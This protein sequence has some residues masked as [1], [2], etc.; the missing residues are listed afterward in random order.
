MYVPTDE[1]HYR[2]SLTHHACGRA[3]LLGVC[4]RPQRG[5]CVCASRGSDTVCVLIVGEVDCSPYALCVN[6]EQKR[7]V[8]PAILVRRRGVSLSLRL[9]Y[10]KSARDCFLWR[11]ILSPALSPPNRE[12]G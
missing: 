9:R 10:L 3:H 8:K 11:V 12:L 5:P 1:S 7:A 6:P 4:T 2:H